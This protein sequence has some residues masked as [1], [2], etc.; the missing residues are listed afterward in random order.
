M[1]RLRYGVGMSLDGYIADPDGGTGFL[2]SDKTF[3]PGPFFRSIDTVVMGRLTWEAA[4]RAGMKGGYPGMRTFICSRTLPADLHPEI[5]VIASDVEKRVAALKEESGKDIWLVGGGVLLRS[6]LAANL[7]DT[8]EVGVS[9]LLLG[10]PGA[11]MLSALPP[12]AEPLR[13]ELTLSETY[14][15]GMVALEYTIKRD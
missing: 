14:P 7:V 13:L 6:L 15:S 8:I 2:V 3:D 1:R 5:S 11:P 4:F 9:P 10:E 12:L